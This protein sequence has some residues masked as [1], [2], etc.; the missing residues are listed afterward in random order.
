M[1]LL[2]IAQHGFIFNPYINLTEK[3]SST[4]KTS[5]CTNRLKSIVLRPNSQEEIFTTPERVSR[6]NVCRL[7]LRLARM[8]TELITRVILIKVVKNVP[9]T[10]STEEVVNGVAARS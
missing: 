4:C 1:N 7:R 9:I 8:P 3:S 5:T 10:R 2:L 6:L